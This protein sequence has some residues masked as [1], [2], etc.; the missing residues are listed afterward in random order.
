L[1]GYS[2]TLGSENCRNTSECND[3]PFF[4]LGVVVAQAAYTAFLL[5]PLT[6][7]ASDGG[8][9]MVLFYWQM[10]DS[11]AADSSA[12]EVVISSVASFNLLIP[13]SSSSSF[14]GI[15]PF[16]G[17]QLLGKLLIGY[18][19]PFLTLGTL[20]LVII[21]QKYRCSL[22]QC[23]IRSLVATVALCATSIVKPTFDLLA[24]THMNNGTEVTPKMYLLKAAS[25]Q[26]FQ[27]WQ[28]LLIILMLL[29]LLLVCVLWLFMRQRRS[30]SSTAH[31]A[32][33]F[34]TAPYHDGF[35]L[36]PLY[37]LA[38]RVCLVALGTLI[39]D[40][41]AKALCLFSWCLFALCAHSAVRPFI[42]T[43][44]GS[45]QYALL[46]SLVFI[47]GTSTLG[48]YTEAVAENPKSSIKFQLKTV[49]IVQGLVLVWP[50]LYLVARTW[51]KKREVQ[52]AIAS[53]VSSFWH[54]CAVWCRWVQ[55]K[56]VQDNNGPRRPAGGSED[57]LSSSL[58]LKW[59]VTDAD[60]ITDGPGELEAFTAEGAP[61]QQV[62]VT[63][64]LF[65]VSELDRQ[66]KEPTSDES[67]PRCRQLSVPIGM[68]L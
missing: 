11:V 51:R 54:S 55:R 4:F 27:W 61:R 6:S 10:A 25:V 24:C 46:A 42:S 52:Y 58:L 40:P 59:A 43:E 7:S 35:E 18:V 50:F 34:A 5:S 66:E 44:V 62:G 39:V 21:V 12:L 3:A 65:G 19:P 56:C 22:D 23:Y 67:V 31:G 45:L 53:C 2:A 26:C 16:K 14:S 1:D 41:I 64:P 47:A 29:L 8:I 48:A 32:Y 68:Q 20:L 13:S 17:L 33:V 37:L 15:C 9:S 49:Q 63:E 30:Q 38:H 28:Y 36:W 60:E 57:C